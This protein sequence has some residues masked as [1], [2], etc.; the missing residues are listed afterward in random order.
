MKNAALKII[1]LV[2][3]TF[4]VACGNDPVAPMIAE[5]ETIVID[6]YGVTKTYVTEV[7][8][9]NGNEV[10]VVRYY[11]DYRQSAQKSFYYNIDMN[12]IKRIDYSY[13]DSDDDFTIHAERNGDEQLT[14]L[15]DPS[16]SSI[17]DI[18]FSYSQDRRTS[19]SGTDYRATHTYNSSGDLE[20]SRKDNYAVNLRWVDGVLNSFRETMYGISFKMTYNY[21]NDRIFDIYQDDIVCNISY[22]DQGRISEI[23]TFYIDEVR[24]VIT[25]YHYREGT[26]VGVQPTP[27]FP[28]G[29]YFGMDGKPLTE[30]PEVSLHGY[31]VF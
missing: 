31:N 1:G 27:A 28:G 12:R 8:Y 17:T 24:E 18:R 4:M 10:D 13:P 5:I 29:Q 21:F 7:D 19:E 20:N 15:Y 30:I 16:T 11:E 3:L 25:T 23:H 9:R 6:G 2:T 22:D 26:V 14:R